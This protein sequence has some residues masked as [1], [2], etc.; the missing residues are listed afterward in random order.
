[1]QIVYPPRAITVPTMNAGVY[2][3]TG[4]SALYGLGVAPSAPRFRF[5]AG[6]VRVIEEKPVNAPG[7]YKQAIRQAFAAR[8]FDWFSDNPFSDYY[9]KL[10]RGK[11]NA[12][13]DDLVAASRKFLSPQ[14]IDAAIKAGKEDFV[15]DLKSDSAK[16]IVGLLNAPSVTSEA[17]VKKALRALF[18]GK[19]YSI[20]SIGT[21]K[22][23]SVQRD[24][25]AYIWGAYGRL[26]F[27]DAQA[28]MDSLVDQ[29][30]TF[31]SAGKPAGPDRAALLEKARKADL[32]KKASPGKRCY[33]VDGDIV[34]CPKASVADATSTTSTP[35]IS[36]A[37]DANQAAIDAKKAQDEANAKAEEARRA[38]WKALEERTA[39]AEAEAAKA[40]EAARQ[41]Q[42][43]AEAAIAEAKRLIEEARASAA[44][45]PMPAPA[46]TTTVT[47]TGEIVVTP[48]APAAQKSNTGAIVAGVVALAAIAGGIWWARRRPASP[49]V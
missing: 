24:A 35:S 33:G 43:D 19:G 17:D 37:A 28:F 8:G 14:E 34:P 30:A 26:G 21:Q 32:L 7:Y 18:D 2:Q 31:K 3:Y 25:A 11:I 15:W 22:A 39:S 4:R 42:A 13:R 44:T 6:I 45:Q 46:P 38:E 40:R 29:S 36:P 1:M 5:T 20:P 9:R 12:V 10:A 41:A 47:P 48:P 23:E 27:K 49:A 16:R